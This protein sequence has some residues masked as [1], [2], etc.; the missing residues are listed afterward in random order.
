MPERCTKQT[1][2]ENSLPSAENIPPSL[3]RLREAL[4]GEPEDD[5]SHAECRAMLPEFVE[6]EAAGEPVARHYPRIKHH[7]DHCDECGQEYALLLDLELAEARGDIEFVSAVSTSTPRAFQ[8]M[9]RE[10][11]RRILHSLAPANLR[12]LEVIADTFFARVQQLGTFELRLGNTQAMGLGQRDTNPALTILAA[13]YAATQTV[14]REITRAQF[15]EWAQAKTL[16]G[17]IET[18]VNRAAREIGIEREFAA[19][20]ARAYTEQIAREPETLRALLI[21]D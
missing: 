10:L 14:T 20:F 1:S 13:S 3:Q 4:W 12:D 2:M 19:Q 8:D 17:E 9:L 16:A 21:Q 11:A 6:A 15:D 7:L 18:R 5:I